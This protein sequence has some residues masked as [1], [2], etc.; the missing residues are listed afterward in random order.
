MSERPPSPERPKKEPAHEPLAD[1][2]PYNTKIDLQQQLSKDEFEELIGKTLKD[3]KEREEFTEKY[4]KELRDALDAEDQK[5]VEEVLGLIG[6]GIHTLTPVQPGGK[7]GEIPGAQY[8]NKNYVLYLAS[9]TRG[10]RVRL[11][12]RDYEAKDFLTFNPDEPMYSEDLQEGFRNLFGDKVVE[13]RSKYATP[14]DLSEL[15]IQFRGDKRSLCPCGS[16]KEFGN[17]HGK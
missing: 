16:E 13:I 5:K 9:G 7:I 17:C 8:E 1:T 11:S 2:L 4:L 6:A 3:K 10:Q 15:A 12:L 14:E